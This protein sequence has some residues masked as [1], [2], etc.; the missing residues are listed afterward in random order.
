LL[1]WN[2]ILPYKKEMGDLDPIYEEILIL[3]D[4]GKVVKEMQTKRHNCARLII[5][6]II[7]LYY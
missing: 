2:L 6:S 3:Q 5:I 1:G 4:D 7:I